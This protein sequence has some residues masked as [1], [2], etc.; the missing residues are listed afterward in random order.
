M[1]ES[2]ISNRHHPLKNNICHLLSVSDAAI[3]LLTWQCCSIVLNR[4][5]GVSDPSFFCDCCQSRAQV[6]V[7]QTL[8][9]VAHFFALSSS[10]LLYYERKA[11]ICR[12][13]W[14]AD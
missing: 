13:G 4:N 8:M 11:C 3:K 12:P 2:F 1:H 7:T 9:T 6:I 5:L 14:L 10:L